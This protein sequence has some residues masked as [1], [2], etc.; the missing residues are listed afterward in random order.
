MAQYIWVPSATFETMLWKPLTL[1]TTETLWDKPLTWFCALTHIAGNIFGSLAT[2]LCFWKRCSHP[3]KKKKRKKRCQVALINFGLLMIICRWK[4][5]IKECEHHTMMLDTVD[6]KAI[7]FTTR[8]KP[9]NHH[10]SHCFQAFHIPS[11]R[12]QSL[13]KKNAISSAPST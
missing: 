13:E 1:K 8:G 10:C 11:F 5:L 3:K 7:R 6:L 12:I 2:R 9:S 4:T